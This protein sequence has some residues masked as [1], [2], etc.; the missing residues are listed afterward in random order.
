MQPR[1]AAAST[2]PVIFPQPGL[3]DDLGTEPE[4]VR[5]VV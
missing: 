2:R 4:K 5:R 3:P 1:A